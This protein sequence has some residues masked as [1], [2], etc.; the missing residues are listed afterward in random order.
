MEKELENAINNYGGKHG[1]LLYFQGSDQHIEIA[2]SIVDAV[3]FS[4]HEEFTETMF[5]KIQTLC[6]Q[7]DSNSIIIRSSERS[8]LNRMVDVFPTFQKVKIEFTNIKNA[9]DHI[10]YFCRHSVKKFA[11]IEGSD[12]SPDK[13]TISIAPQIPQSILTVTEHP[14]REGVYYFDVDRGAMSIPESDYFG[15]PEK[16]PYFE[17]V[18]AIIEKIR[19][20]FPDNMALQLE[21]GVYRNNRLTHMDPYLFQIRYLGPKKFANYELTR[22]SFPFEPQ[23]CFGVLPEEGIVLPI[24][25][26]YRERVRCLDEFEE[27]KP[28]VDYVFCPTMT[29]VPLCRC[30]NPS[31]HMKGYVPLIGLAG[32]SPSMQHQHTRFVQRALNAEGFSIIGIVPANVEEKL[33]ESPSARF[34]CD[35]RNVAIDNI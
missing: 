8:D 35:G 2:D 17:K 7:Y 14:N 22:D 21:F 29:N 6:S 10:R 23:R 31:P 34:F 32:S 18:M 13:V 11:G 24:A 15:S 20:S 27:R 16:E 4:I 19:N 5:K 9:I 26:A 33:S 3:V 1:P 28:G 30:D 12:Y 25:N